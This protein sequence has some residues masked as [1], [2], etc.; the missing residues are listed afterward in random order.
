MHTVL[1]DRAELR[2]TAAIFV[3][4]SSFTRLLFSLPVRFLSGAD[5]VMEI[6]FFYQCLRFL[7]VFENLWRGGNSSWASFQTPAD[8]V[9]FFLQ[10]N[11]LSRL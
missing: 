6:A 4:Q 9:L 7:H 11:L 2:Q 10:L 5:L 8:M 3:P 1:Y